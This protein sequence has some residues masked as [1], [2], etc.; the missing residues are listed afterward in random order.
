MQ[1]AFSTGYVRH[2][3][4]LLVP[5]LGSGPHA[6]GRAHC[7]DVPVLLAPPGTTSRHRSARG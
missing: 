3:L 7:Q 4:H 6:P 5:A 2:P 1:T